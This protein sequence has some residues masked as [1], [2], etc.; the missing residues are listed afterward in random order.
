MRDRLYLRVPVP[1]LKRPLQGALLLIEWRLVPH[2]CVKGLLQLSGGLMEVVH[3]W[4]VGV[5]LLLLVVEAVEHLG[6][7][8]MMR[9]VLL[10]LLL[11]RELI[12]VLGIVHHLRVGILPLVVL[13]L[14]H[15]TIHVL[16]MRLMLLLYLFL[17]LVCESGFPTL[18]KYLLDVL[19]DLHG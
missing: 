9:I 1:H 4:G 5:L 15:L 18:Q 3:H 11:L 12:L 8:W 2:L 6:N 10:L 14:L 16:V 19:L 7:I 17:Y 13:L